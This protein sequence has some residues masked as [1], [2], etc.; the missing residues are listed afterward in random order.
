MVGTVLRFAYIIVFGISLLAGL[1]A[2]DYPTDYLAPVRHPVKLSG[3]FGE[4]RTSHFHMGIDIKSSKGVEGDDILAVQDGFVSRIVVQA[5]GYGNALYIDHP[6]GWTSVYAHLREF[7]PAIARYVEELQYESERFE[8]DVAPPAGLFTI[9]KGEVIAQMGNTGWSFGPHL[10]FEL[11]R[12]VTEVAHNPLHLGFELEDSRPPVLKRILSYQLDQKLR[13]RYT[14]HRALVRRS[15]HYS[16]GSD[17]LDVYGDR[18]GIGFVAFDQMEGV[19]N[20]NGIYGAEVWLDYQPLFS[21]NFD[22]I[23]YPHSRKINAHLDHS[24][25]AM[26]GEKV[27]RCYAPP[28]NGLPIHPQPQLGGM[29]KLY[30]DQPA[31]LKLIASD[32]SGNKSEARVWLRR[33]RERGENRPYSRV[34]PWD[35]STSVITPELA[36]HF[37]EH[38]MPEDLFLYLKTGQSGKYA[39]RDSFFVGAYDQRPMKKYRMNIPLPNT[40]AQ[41]ALPWTVLW[42]SEAGVIRNMGGEIHNDTLTVQLDRFGQ[43]LLSMDTIPPAIRPVRLYKNMRKYHSIEFTISDNWDVSGNARELRY[44]AT[45]NDQW[46]LFSY[47]LKNRRIRFKFPDWMEAGTYELSLSVWDDRDNEVRFTHKF[48]YRP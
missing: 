37:E 29:I 24:W 43:F 32:F 41:L 33:Q 18:A 39:V 26:S 1:G 20:R 47:D 14:D 15:E 22:S 45:M 46:V 13:K 6:D 7:A 9:K 27:H 28:G 3:T 16:T 19:Y 5:A 23:P 30:R 2:Q 12:T 38:A 21:F 42:V 25:M 31:E 11:R 10:H 35:R 40:E 34:I 48:H 44:R 8:L 17:T 36:L 4:L